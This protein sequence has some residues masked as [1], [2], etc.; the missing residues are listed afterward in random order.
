MIVGLASLSLLGGQ[1]S[2]RTTVST[3]SFDA[4]NGQV[5]IYFNLTSRSQV[6]P[7]TPETS[8]EWDLA[9]QRHRIKSNG[10]DSGKGGVSVTWLDAQDFDALKT[11]PSPSKSTY[12]ID[13]HAPTG[14]TIGD[15]HLA[16][17]GN[18]GWYTYSDTH[19]LGAKNRVYVVKTTGGKY[20]KLQMLGYYDAAG[21][22]G[23]P[24]FKY[25]EI[26][27]PAN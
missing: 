24:R 21:T 10:G 13:S 22:S 14:N 7:A 27:P 26:D 2:A 11:A 1:A 5:W 25:A 15:R 23:N 19:K 20:V 16:F 6:T 3:Q 8:G 18:D 12:V 4:S 17:L 9:F